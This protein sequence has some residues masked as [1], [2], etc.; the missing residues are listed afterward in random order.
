MEPDGYR[1]ESAGTA[2]DAE[3]EDQAAEH[4][5]QE[6]A[7]AALGTN[8]K[9]PLAYARGSVDSLPYRVRHDPSVHNQG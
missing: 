2:I 5:D 7:L 3:S 6:R 9:K 1:G 8:L 4:R